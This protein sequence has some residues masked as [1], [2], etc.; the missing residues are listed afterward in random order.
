M[1]RALGFQ[2]TGR[3][4]RKLWLASIAAFAPAVS[5][6]Y[7]WDVVAHVTQI[8]PVALPDRIFF[9][10]DVSAGSCAAG[11]WLVFAAASTNT[12]NPVENVKGMYAG[13][14]ASLHAG[15]SVEVYG[16]NS[17]CTVSYIHFLAN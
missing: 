9:A 8:E 2:S 13:L 17:G 10:I 11:P 15:T 3:S 7:D 5:L 12:S 1:I 6:A 4:M 14:L 16:N